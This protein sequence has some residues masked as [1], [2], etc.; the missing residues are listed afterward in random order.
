MKKQ[1]YQAPQVS[2]MHM[3]AANQLLS[4]SPAGVG[5]GGTTSNT[6][7]DAPVRRFSPTPG[8]GTN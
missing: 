3:I 6:T 7:A 5:I 1:Y 8:L 2:V 4:E